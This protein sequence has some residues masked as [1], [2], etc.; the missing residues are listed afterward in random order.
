MIKK[1]PHYPIEDERILTKAPKVQVL[2]PQGKP[3]IFLDPTTGVYTDI[4][5]V[6]VT[7]KPR[8][9][10]KTPPTLEDLLAP[11][12]EKQPSWSAILS[13]IA[14]FA[15]GLLAAGGILLA[16]YNCVAHP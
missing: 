2:R 3:A 11:E 13:L 7:L 5:G 16:L 10:V 12:A 14:V 9:P 15:L 6:P 8:K 1:S 4:N